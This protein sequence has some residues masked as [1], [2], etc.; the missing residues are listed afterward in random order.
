VSRRR[1]VTLVLLGVLL[2]AAAWLLRPLA[3]GTASTMA[4]RRSA[5]TSTGPL[6]DEFVQRLFDGWSAVSGALIAIG[7]ALA[8]LGVVFG[9]RRRA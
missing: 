6:A 4:A 3:T 1:S 8:I 2:A 7:V 9:L 5:E